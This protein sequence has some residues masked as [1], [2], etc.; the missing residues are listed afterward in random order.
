[1]TEH[2]TDPHPE[3]GRTSVWELMLD[4][5]VAPGRAMARIADE[6]PVG[7]AAVLVT[8]LAAFTGILGVAGARGAAAVDPSLLPSDLPPEVLDLMNAFMGPAAVFGAV[9]G[10]LGSLLWWFARAAIYGLIGELVGAQRDGRALLATLGFAALPMLLRAPID[11]MLS[12]LGATWPAI[13]VGLVFWV[14]TL[15]LTV[16]AIRAALRTE[17]GWAIV[18]YLIPVGVGIALA[19]VAGLAFFIAIVSAASQMPLP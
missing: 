7:A 3:T 11:L 4:V 12:R 8:G 10:V 2:M 6:R 5:F 1:M 15:I 14:W 17:T 19:M 13:L 16:L 9:F 18:I